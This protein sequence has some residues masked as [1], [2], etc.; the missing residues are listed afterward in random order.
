VS[1]KLHTLTSTH[2]TPAYGDLH[3]HT[4][5]T[6][7][8][9]AL[10]LQSASL[11]QGPPLPAA[12]AVSRG[13]ASRMGV[14]RLVTAISLPSAVFASCSERSGVPKP[15]VGESVGAVGS[16]YTLRSSE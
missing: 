9:R 1:Q 8:P 3:L 15:V 13:S 16:P 12:V 5:A 14:V 4:L 11:A 6:H 7:A 10:P 2:L